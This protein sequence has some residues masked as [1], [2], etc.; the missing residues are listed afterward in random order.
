MVTL[1]SGNIF[2]SSADVLVNPVNK[3]G[4][5]GKGLALQFKERFPGNHK[6]Y[7]YW[8]DKPKEFSRKRLY[9]YYRPLDEGMKYIANLAT[10]DDWR[11]PSSYAI[12]EEGLT[13]LKEWAQQTLV[14][15]IAMPMLGC[16]CGGLDPEAVMEL[17]VDTFQNEEVEILLYIKP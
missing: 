6:A 14:N 4:V 13:E 9:I 5:A 7:R 8:C 15:S 17:I 3:M 1:T 2:D 10:K 16:G 11:N 12:I